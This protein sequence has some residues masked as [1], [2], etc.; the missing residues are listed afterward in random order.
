MTL[1]GTHTWIKNDCVIELNAPN[2]PQINSQCSYSNFNNSYG[3]DFRGNGIIEN[4]EILGYP[5]S[6]EEV[7]SSEYL[8]EVQYDFTYFD[9]A[10]NNNSEVLTFYYDTS[11]PQ[12]T[13]GNQ[14]ISDGDV[15]FYS[16]WRSSN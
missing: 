14:V 2:A 1:D 13:F 7:S 8:R 3:I 15:L 16:I 11:T 10:T 4:F 5:Y 12:I 9:K 6:G